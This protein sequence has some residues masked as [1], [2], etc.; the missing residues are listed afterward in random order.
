MISLARKLGHFLLF[1]RTAQQQSGKN[2]LQQ[3][4]DIHALRGM[5]GQCGVSDYY[6]FKLYDRAYLSGRGH[7][8]YL[9]WRLQE[10]FNLALNP[11]YAVLPA[12]DKMV[13]T[14]I[15]TATGLPVAPTLAC[16]HPANRLS[17]VFGLHLKNRE[18]VGRFIR[19]PAVYPLFGKPA[20]SQQGHGAAYLLAY[21]ALTDSLTQLNGI[22]LSADEFLNR[23]EQTVDSRYHKPECG[24][25][26]QE[27]LTLAPEI[28]AL[29]NWSAICGV[30]IICLNGSE[31]VL[32]ISAAFKIAVSPNQVDNF[33]G[34]KYGNLNAQIDLATGEIKRVLNAYWPQAELLLNHPVT[35][36]R[37]EGFKL[38]HWQLL[39]DICHRA[40]AVF[41]LMKV[42]HWDFAL[43]D[44]GPIILELNDLGGIDIDQAYGVGLLTVATRKFLKQNVDAI[45]HP[46][47]RAL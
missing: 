7:E 27:P 2:L 22:S 42:H 23:V 13:F 43:T 28:H 17:E 26:F 21:D 3:L 31:G 15:A 29:T 33:S 1:A 41:P 46:W 16:F 36:H 38:P 45:A 35:G 18:E 14:M 34:G 32:P 37:L 9:G 6:Q 39:L 24:Y 25:I 5:G 19:N 30:R 44:K 20:F 8:D 11:R 12:W 10:K 4:R 40:G 47:V